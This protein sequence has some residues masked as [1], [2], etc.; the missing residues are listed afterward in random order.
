MPRN[1]GAS[2]AVQSDAP[3]LPNCEG[4]AKPME[5]IPPVKKKDARNEVCPKVFAFNT[6]EANYVPS[7]NV[8]DRFKNMGDVIVIVFPLVPLI[9]RHSSSFQLHAFDGNSA[10]KHKSHRPPVRHG[11]LS[12]VTGHDVTVTCNRFATPASAYIYIHPVIYASTS[13]IHELS[14]IEADYPISQLTTD[15]RLAS[16]LPAPQS[17][18]WRILSN[19]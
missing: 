8:I 18:C 16:V 6:A 7:R 14:Y 13:D 10:T 12:G 15:L 2:N 5:G 11:L 1:Q 4:N 9:L 17:P 3:S 19:K